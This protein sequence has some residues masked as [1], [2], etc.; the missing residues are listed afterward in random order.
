MTP[1]EPDDESASSSLLRGPSAWVL[2]DAPHL[3]RALGTRPWLSRWLPFKVADAALRGVAQVCFANNPVSGLLILVGLFL[4][5]ANVGLAT[6]VCSLV[7][8]A[9]AKAAGQ[10]D[11]AVCAGLCSYCAVLVGTVTAALHPA[12]A[13][14]A[15]P[16]PT[17]W[18]YTA[19]AASYSV[20]VGVALSAVLRPLNVPF[21]TL[22]FNVATSILFLVFAASVETDRLPP[23]EAEEPLLNA[24]LPAPDWSEVLSGSV[25]AAGQVYGVEHLLCSALTMVALALN[26]PLLAVTSY[27]GGLVGTLAAL[28]VTNSAQQAAVVGG[29]WGYN[30]FL[31]AGC[32]VFF[33]QP[34]WRVALL[35]L[36]NALSATVIHVAFVPVF[37]ANG[38]PVFTFP[39]CTASALLL[40]SDAHLP[41]VRRVPVLS[42]P[43]E[44]I[45]TSKVRAAALS[46]SE[47]LE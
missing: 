29:V 8:V 12:L 47:G 19:A 44:H 45:H 17:A 22:P 2:G 34:S 37:A 14:S 6:V 43:E 9:T 46:R 27:V 32:A 40:S 23:P 20:V 26:S 4:S 31:A 35:A 24:T 1:P 13:A 30:G 25:L 11:S 7:A 28:A 42:Y 33:L 39:F 3:T 15:Q 38:L 36:F 21:F 41:A 16:A 5:G 18:L 10:P